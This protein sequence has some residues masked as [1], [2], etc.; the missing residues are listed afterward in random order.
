MS[1]TYHHPAFRGL[2]SLV[3]Y[4][5]ANDPSP[6]AVVWAASA[7]AGTVSLV[8]VSGVSGQILLTL[9]PDVKPWSI[10]WKAPFLSVWSEDATALYQIAGPLHALVA[11]KVG[12]HTFTARRRGR[13]SSSASVPVFFG[14]S[15]DAIVVVDARGWPPAVH[16]IPYRASYDAVVV[17]VRDFGIVC[18]TGA[19][20]TVVAT[21]PSPRVM[22]KFP[23][24][25]VQG[26]R[27]VRPLPSGCVVGSA[28]TNMVSVF[29]LA[30]E[31][32]VD[33][34]VVS[35]LC[36]AH[37][38]VHIRNGADDTM[39]GTVPLFT[40]VCW[41]FRNRVHAEALE[42]LSPAYGSPAHDWERSPVADFA[43]IPAVVLR[44][45]EPVD[46]VLVSS[47]EAFKY[48]VKEFS[49][50]LL[51]AAFRRHAW[52]VP[53]THAVFVR[54]AGLVLGH[55]EDGALSW[56]HVVYAVSSH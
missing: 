8:D 30:S 51:W 16:E 17:A 56:G 26:P 10:A 38:A 13:V 12:E 7:S 49:S 24:S 35:V 14:L 39:S 31:Y 29:A 22:S 45:D 33:E 27:V 46:A 6:P 4:A 19:C 48:R 52:V 54:G 2:T 50:G 34:P 40:E 36:G 23:A 20:G 21:A 53:V 5:D 18:E 3:G 41:R 43:E 44:S 42:A 25:H 47:S 37:D 1:I 55:G 28:S 15:G 9:T 32:R 11:T